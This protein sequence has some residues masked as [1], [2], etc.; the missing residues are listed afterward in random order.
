L[1][2]IAVRRSLD[3]NLEGASGKT[4]SAVA[5]L[6]AVASVSNGAQ[7]Q[8]SNLP[9]VSVGAPVGRPRPV[10]SKPSP[11]QVRA[12]NTLQRPAQRQQAQQAAAVASQSAGAPDRNPYAAAAPYKVNHLQA[13]GKFPERLLDDGTLLAAN[14][15]TSIPGYWRFDV[16]AGAKVD[17]LWTVKLFVNDIFDKRYYDALYQSATPFVLEAPGRAALSGALGGL[18]RR[19]H[20]VPC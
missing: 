13:S 5:S 14:Q 15:G 17:K 3:E 12:R 20:E 18:L 1:R 9:P 6:I 11:E 19:L 7:A 10:A 4:V 2:S 8:Q 16:F